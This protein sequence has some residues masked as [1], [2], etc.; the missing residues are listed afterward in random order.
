MRKLAFGVAALLTAALL[1][2][3]AFLS[4]AAPAATQGAPK[5]DLVMSPHAASGDHAAHSPQSR[6]AGRIP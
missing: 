2:A 6:P 4:I 5:L 1:M 3:L